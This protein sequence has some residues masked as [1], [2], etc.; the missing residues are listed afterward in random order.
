MHH[1]TDSL[2]VR[3]YFVTVQMPQYIYEVL[4][5]QT[6]SMHF[7]YKKAKF[8]RMA[9]MHVHTFTV[10]DIFKIKQ[11]QVATAR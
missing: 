4:A 9:C 1:M 6:G 2:D 7:S 8:N 3:M 10:I 5:S 11:L